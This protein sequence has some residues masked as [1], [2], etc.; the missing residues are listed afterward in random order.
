MIDYRPNTSILCLE[1][2]NYV[3][4]I[5]IVIG[6]VLKINRKETIVQPNIYL[7]ETINFKWKIILNVLI[8]IALF[9]KPTISH[10][11]YTVM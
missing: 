2:R 6:V 11:R 8:Y 9:I 3:Y 10:A 1:C 4:R 7:F 5:F